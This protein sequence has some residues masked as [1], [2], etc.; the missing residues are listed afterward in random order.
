[1]ARKWASTWSSTSIPSAL[2]K[3]F[4]NRTI[5]L[6]MFCCSCGAEN[7]NNATVCWQCGTA[8]I[9]LSASVSSQSEKQPHTAETQHLRSLS[10]RL[11]AIDPKEDVCHG[12]GGKD[13]LTVYPFGLAKKLGR[14]WHVAETIASV[15]ISAVSL[16]LVG[17]GILRLPGNTTTFQVLRMKLVLCP[18]CRKKRINYELHPWFATV[19][20]AGFTKFM[21]RYDLEEIRPSAQKS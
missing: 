12:C 3:L 11:A 15:G 6:Y 1:M 2:T 10:E 8:F 9:Q 7:P 21:D 19:S 18:N 16:P 5:L 17:L 20:H 4:S 14:E 13:G